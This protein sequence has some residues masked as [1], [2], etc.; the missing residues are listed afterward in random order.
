VTLAVHQEPRLLFAVSGA[1]E[2]EATGFC[3]TKALTENEPE[4][5]TVGCGCWL[6]W[7]SSWPRV[8]RYN[9]L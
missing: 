3:L 8:V 9:S 7:M 2:P 6:R 1:V 5:R 4:A